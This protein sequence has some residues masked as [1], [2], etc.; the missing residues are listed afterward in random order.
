[1]NLLA[2]TTSGIGLTQG[3][4]SLR[5]ALVSIG[6][7]GP[8][9]LG[10]HH[11]NHQPT[12]ALYPQLP[13]GIRRHWKSAYL[14]SSIGCQDTFHKSIELPVVRD[15]DIEAALPFQAESLLPFPSEESVLSSQTISKSPSSSTINL[16]AVRKSAIRTH[17]DQFSKLNIEPEFTSL[18]PVALCEFG[19]HFSDAKIILHIDESECFCAVHEQKKLLS[20]HTSE[21]TPK[22]L[23]DLQDSPDAIQTVTHQLIKLIYATSRDIVVSEK[24]LLL[25][26]SFASNKALLRSLEK[27]LRWKVTLPTETVSWSSEEIAAY[28][29]PIGLASMASSSSTAPTTDVRKA[30]FAYPHPWRRLKKPLSVYLFLCVVL[31][32]FIHFNASLKKSQTKELIRE[33]YRAILSLAD[34]PFEE[35]ENNYRKR[36]FLPLLGES[37][38][39][40]IDH[41]RVSEISARLSFLEKELAKE[42]ET[43]RLMPNIPRVSDVFAWLASHP[44]VVEVNPATGAVKPLLKL[45]SFTYTIV[46]RP[47][48]GRLKERYQAKIDLEISASTP[49][50]ARAF[51]D[52][53]IEPNEFVD[54]KAEIKWSSSRGKYRT[55]FYLKSAP[56]YG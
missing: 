44:A 21:V 50:P 20:F 52:A 27:E 49:S 25:T 42:A 4:G 26:G 10:L 17:I 56:S 46:K 39:I 34:M 36:N 13:K 1:M 15:A 16:F 3:D 24:K 12:K 40:K 55:S 47:V 5:L 2:D 45:E 28:A 18:S 19:H 35:V 54:S 29:V 37:G 9:I 14:V 38:Q 41:L 31:T 30:E 7:K 22:D 51:H 23:S 11:L 32:L 48:K 33:K 6:E 43:F 53:L 8:K